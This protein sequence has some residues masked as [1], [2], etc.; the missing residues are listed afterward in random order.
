MN[1][2]LTKEQN[3]QLENIIE[4]LYPET[5]ISI[6]DLAYKLEASEDNIENVLIKLSEYKIIDPLFILR[7]DNDEFDYIH[8]F[9]F[10]SFQKLSNFVNKNNA[11]C[12]DCSSNFIDSNVEVY[13]KVPKAKLKKVKD[14]G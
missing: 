8:T 1:Q 13:F 9:S 5:I 12:P 11:I 7:C 10:D 6:E 2:F 14:N 4:S 3:N